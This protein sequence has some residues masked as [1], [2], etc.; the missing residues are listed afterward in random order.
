MLLVTFRP[1]SIEPLNRSLSTAI[2]GCVCGR[3]NQPSYSHHADHITGFHTSTATSYARAS[4]SP[5]HYMCMCMVVMQ[6]APTVR[7]LC[8]SVTCETTRHAVPDSI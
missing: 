2:D 6:S 3:T 4:H 7:R 8:Y 1:A 5:Q